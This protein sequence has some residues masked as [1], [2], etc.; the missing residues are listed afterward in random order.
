MPIS[1]VNFL[2]LIDP[3]DLQGIFAKRFGELVF[4]NV[5]YYVYNTFRF[6]ARNM[7]CRNSSL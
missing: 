2:W 1:P 4:P 7:F 3:H 6:L 5:K